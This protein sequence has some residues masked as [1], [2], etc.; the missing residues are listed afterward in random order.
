MPRC[1]PL[2][3][4]MLSTANAGTRS[5]ACSC[6]G[7]HPLGSAQS[8]SMPEQSSMLTSSCLSGPCPES[9]ICLPVGPV[10][11]CHNVQ[12]GVR[13]AMISTTDGDMCNVHARR[14][15]TLCRGSL[16][17]HTRGNRRGVCVCVCVCA[18][19]RVRVRV[20]VVCVL[21]VRMCV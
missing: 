12:A 8:V 9:S 20:R 13:R 15:A 3:V 14:N 18:C 19:V 6:Q 21:C 4:S 2:S 5:G 17:I 7:T 16:S 11:A 10:H 1:V